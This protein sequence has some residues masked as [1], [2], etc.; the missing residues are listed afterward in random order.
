M[1]EL[2]NGL[3]LIMTLT[4]Y[5]KAT[6]PLTDRGWIIKS[7]IYTHK[8]GR[9]TRGTNASIILLVPDVIILQEKK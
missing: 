6:P 2:N 9:K 8:P 5:R 7:Y 1:S 4:A 3:K